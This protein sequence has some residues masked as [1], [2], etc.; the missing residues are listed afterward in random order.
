MII[1][2][3]LK[4]QCTTFLIAKTTTMKHTLTLL[5]LL[6]ASSFISAQSYNSWYSGDTTDVSGLSPTP[7][8]V[9]AGGAGDNDQAMQWMLSRAD[10]GDVVVIRA[11]GS[12]GYNAYFLSELGEA[13]NSV[14]TIR[15]NNAAAAQNDYVVQQIRNAE[16]LFIAGGDQYDYYQYWKDTPVEEAINYLINEKGVP[17]GGTSAG[18]AILSNCY[19]APSGSSLTAEEALSNPYHP[20]YEVLGKDDF[21]QVPYTEN[22]IP[23]THYDQRDRAGRHIGMLARLAQDHQVRSFGIACNE[24]TAVCIDE[25]GMA[26]AFGEHA[27]F[28]EDIVYFLQANCQEEFLPETITEGTPLTWDRS[29][30]AVKVYAVPAYIDGSGTFDLSSWQNGTGG[31]WQNWYVEEGTLHQEDAE[32]G[33][34]ASVVSSTADLE[35][36]QML[37]VSPNPATNYL[38]LTGWEDGYP[39]QAQFINPL[40]QLVKRGIFNEARINISNLP[41]GAYQVI[42]L[43]EGKVKTARFIKQ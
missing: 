32:D 37:R 5:L 18:M 2:K 22:L 9:L 4:N 39:I 24:Y 35:Y 19:Y 40:G 29:N 34:C 7:G 36:G 28:P 30:S 38:Q 31:F 1:K 10:G 13:V 11:S 33:D 12:D 26:R 6:L 17:V 20:D 14:Q 27:E 42:L 21:L 15:F 3:I 23:D 8:L 25:Q 41:P 43:R 16:C